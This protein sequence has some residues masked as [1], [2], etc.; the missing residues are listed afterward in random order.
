MTLKTCTDNEN[1][2]EIY[3]EDGKIIHQN[4]Q[5]LK[6]YRYTSG[7]IILQYTCSIKIY[8]KF[9]YRTG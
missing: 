7:F 1:G 6:G 3:A 5:K 9:V 8:K 2:H 4:L